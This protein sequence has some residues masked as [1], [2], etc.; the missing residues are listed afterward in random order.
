M[1]H[2]NDYVE[3]VSLGVERRVNFF[4]VFTLLLIK[5][6]LSNFDCAPALTC[7]NEGFWHGLVLLSSSAFNP[8][9]SLVL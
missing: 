3:I 6:H 2:E 5:R 1:E 7:V 4:G 9:H 8:R